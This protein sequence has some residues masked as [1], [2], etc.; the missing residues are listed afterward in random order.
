MLSRPTIEQTY[1]TATAI[2]RGEEIESLKKTTR[3]N[4]EHPTMAVRPSD[5]GSPSVLS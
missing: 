4:E 3:T 1:L 2:A 5:I